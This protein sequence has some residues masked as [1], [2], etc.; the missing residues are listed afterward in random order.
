VKNKVKISKINIKIGDK[1]IPLTLEEAQEL[2][3]ILDDTFGQKTVFY[4]ST[5]VIIERPY[6]RPYP[7]P[8]W[9]ISYE[10][11]TGVIGSAA[12]FT[13]NSDGANSAMNKGDFDALPVV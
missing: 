7:Y 1:E 8:Y 13:L 2:R 4:P 11:T 6:V 3:Q 9:S 12:T 5:P 10:N